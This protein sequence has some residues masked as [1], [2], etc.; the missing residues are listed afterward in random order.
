MNRDPAV[1]RSRS[2]ISSVF[3]GSLLAVSTACATNHGEKPKERPDPDAGAGSAFGANNEFGERNGRGGLVNPKV[4]VVFDDINSVLCPVDTQFRAGSDLLATGVPV[5]TKSKTDGP[6][7]NRVTWR[8]VYPDL[9]PIREMDGFH[10]ALVF[11]PFMGAGA[12]SFVSEQVNDPTDGIV[13]QVGP[14][15]LRY[16]EAIPV[17]VGYKYSIVRVVDVDPDPDDEEWEILR[18]RNGCEPLDPNIRVY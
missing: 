16:D 7:R 15:R 12:G 8:A 18:G 10:Y 5:L 1:R 13:Q 2:L 17:G 9:T 3:L 11:H 14:H 6:P 4:L